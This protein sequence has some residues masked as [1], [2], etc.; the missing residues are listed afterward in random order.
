MQPAGECGYPIVEAD[1]NRGRESILLAEDEPI[2]R[3]LTTQ[4]LTEAGYNVVAV[5]DGEQALE[6]L[7]ENPDRFDLV[8]LD[9]VMPRK[10][11]AEVWKDVRSLAPKACIL[12]TS[13][14][15]PDSIDA[16]IGEP[17]A[18]AFLP[19]PFTPLDLLCKVRNTLDVGNG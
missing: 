9:M 4:V 12:L 15:A 17:E 18:P 19:K 2:V 7:Q 14:Y 13:G 10:G 6:I 16:R 11:G 1:S 3:D 5:G 8:I